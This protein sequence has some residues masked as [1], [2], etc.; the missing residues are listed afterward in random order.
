VIAGLPRHA[1][2]DCLHDA[3]NALSRFEG[4]DGFVLPACVNL[5]RVSR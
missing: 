3:C 2:D 5:L 4:P 1:Q